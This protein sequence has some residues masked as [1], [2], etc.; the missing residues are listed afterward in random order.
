VH[1]ELGKTVTFRA[2]ICHALPAGRIPTL[3]PDVPANDG[4]ILV[5]FCREGNTGN[6]PATSPD[7]HYNDDDSSSEDLTFSFDFYGILYEKVFINNNGNLSFEQ[8]FS[9]FSAQGFPSN[10]FQMVAAFWADVDTGDALDTNPGALGRVWRKKIANNV[11]AVAW[12]HVG[13]FN[14]QGDLRN[15]FQVV[16]SDGNEPLMGPP[17]TN[18]CF[19]YEDMS[20]TTG[21]EYDISSSSIFTRTT[22]ILSSLSAELLT[23]DFLL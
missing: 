19:C 1:K 14:E 22:L 6:R 7:C 9:T 13:H 16:I 20:W 4:W 17:G 10:D 23:H 5:N 8:W 3:E 18:V 2:P 11:F 21:G 12:D 15:T